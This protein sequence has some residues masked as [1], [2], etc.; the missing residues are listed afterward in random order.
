MVL[1][2]FIFCGYMFWWLMPRVRVRALCARAW[3]DQ[4]NTCCKRDVL[5]LNWVFPIRLPRQPIV[6]FAHL[7]TV[8]ALSTPNSA[9][10]CLQRFP[11]Y[12]GLIS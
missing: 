4:V 8:L 10:S 12:R 1:P 9:P 7:L 6:P 3:Q 11:T 2:F 5:L